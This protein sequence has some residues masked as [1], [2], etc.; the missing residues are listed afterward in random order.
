MMC[1]QPF[2]RNPQ[3]KIRWSTKM[4]AEERLECTPFPCGCCL[5]CRINRARTWQHRIMLEAKSHAH[6]LFVTLTYSKETLPPD[7]SVK[8]SHL[9]SFMKRLRRSIDGIKIRYFAVGEYGERGDRP[10]YHLC[11]FGLSESYTGNIV[12]SWSKNSVPIGFVH[13]G[14]VTAHSARYI[15]GYTIKKLTKVG[16]ERLRGRSPEFMLSSRKEGGIGLKEVLRIAEALKKNEYWDDDTVINSFKIGGRVFP[17]GGYLTTKLLDA[18]GV[19]KEIRDA[20][21]WEYQQKMFNQNLIHTEDYYFNL[22]D[23]TFL[24]RKR[25]EKRHSI[26]KKEKIL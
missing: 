26:Y 16:D 13:V 23:S 8:K 3:G 9:Q 1:S 12:K 22:I 7:G 20:K 6:S 25:L 5:P 19:S 2:M 10:H 14:E 18:L 17:L 24:Q 4:T 21:L 11:L 15:A